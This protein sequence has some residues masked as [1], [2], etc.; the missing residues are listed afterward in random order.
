M[1]VPGNLSS[2]LLATAA[3]AAASD[4]A[5]KSLRF[6]DGETTSLTRTPSS[7]GNRKTWTWSGWVKRSELG[8]SGAVLFSGYSGSVNADLYITFVTSATSSGSE[9]AIALFSPPAGSD[10]S[11]SSNAIFRD[12]SAW[13]HIVVACDT[14][15]STAADRVK[16]YVNG[17]E[18]TYNTTS[19]P[20]QNATLAINDT[21]Q[22]A[23]G[24]RPIDGGGNSN[25]FSG[26]MADI[27]MIDGSS[28]DPTSFGA[29]DDN[30]VWQAV[31]YSG[32]FGTNGFHLLDFANESTVGHDS[33]GN[34]NDFTANNF[35]ADGSKGS[36]YFNGSAGIT[37]TMTAL[38]NQNWTVEMF[39]EK[40]SS[41]GQEALFSFSSDN[42]TFETD[43][44]SKVRWMSS[45]V[46][47]STLAQN[48]RYHIAWVRNSNKGYIY[49]DGTLISP[50]SGIDYSDNDTNTSF[51]IGERT[52]GTTGFT[53]YIDNVRVVVGTAVYTSNFTVPSTPLTAV[54]NTKLLTL[55]SASLSDTSGQNVSLTNG[56]AVEEFASSQDVLFDVPTNGTQ[57]DTGAGGEVS[58]NYAT[59]NP[60]AKASHVSLSNGNLE[61]VNT[62][63]T[64]QSRANATIAISSGKWY[65]EGT[66]TGS[67]AYHEI[68]VITTDMAT[69]NGI[70]FYSGGYAYNQATGEK[71]NNNGTASYGATYATGDVIGVALDLDNGTLVFYKN[72]ASQGTAFTGLSGTF[73]PAMGTYSSVGAFGWTANFG[74]RAFAYSAPSG[75]SPI[76]TTLLP[77]PTIADGSDYFDVDIYSG[78]GSSH[79]RSNFSFNPDWLW[80]KSRNTDAFHTLVD[81]VR[82]GGNFLR[83]NTTDS[84]TT[85]QTDLVTS[86]DSDGFTMGA[87]ANSGDINQSGRTYVCW[88]WDAGSSTASNTDGNITSSVRASAVSGFS[89]V[90]YTGNG[91]SSATVGHGLNAALDFIL[92]KGR[93][94]NSSWNIKHSSLDSNH[95]LQLDT[96]AQSNATNYNSGG[97]AN[98][99]SSS[100]FNFVSGSSGVNNVNASGTTYVAYCFT[101]IAGYSA[102][103]SYTGNGSTNG[104][105]VYTGF[106]PAFV[107]LK[108]IGAGS[109]NWTVHDNK[110]LGYNPDQD[111][112]FPDDSGAENSTS[113]LDFVSNGFKLRTASGFANTS[114]V[115][116]I[117]WAM[118]ENPFSANGGLAR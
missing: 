94:V 49:V 21:K 48:T 81:V 87:N 57:S 35:V 55:T 63:G 64:S 11:I 4:V 41:T 38:G 36:W 10:I 115:E 14:T 8:G 25:G 106:R 99:T 85:G 79:E 98:L 116:Y 72:G 74:Q 7:A 42:P 47:G 27:Y 76:C 108:N 32:T 46:Y 59:F 77:T 44:P 68:G 23:V 97:I 17:A 90:T 96:S 37:G 34:E 75:F 18:V 114:G 20:A 24:S 113:Y 26:F 70:G 43:Q 52:G 5:T 93:S 105:F 19:Y 69:V 89:I 56:G 40:T 102:F 111:L 110:R 2:P 91:S 95:N 92:I 45:S 88:G 112:L 16:I 60:L 15:Q 30:G 117:Y 73:T 6:N 118:A 29:Y 51:S 107:V 83:S 82:G 9:D 67:S 61:A 71:F 28:L 80:F 101:A 66:V 100:T 12:T 65:F 103:G 13:Y 53:G 62:A 78:T 50:S 58:G 86:F 54:S 3:A 39:I 104:T 31:A 84:E 1:T 109:T 22:H 33:S